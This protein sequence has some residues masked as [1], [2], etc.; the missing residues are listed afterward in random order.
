MKR[1]LI[2]FGFMAAAVGAPAGAQTA[3]PVTAPSVAAP[4]TTPSVATRDGLLGMGIL[5]GD[6]TAGTVKYWIDDI[7]AIAGGIGVSENLLLYADYV[8]HGWDL[9]PQPK[10]GRLAA[11]AAIGGRLEFTDDTDFG[12]RALPGVSYWPHFKRPVEF[13][14]EVGPTFRLTKGLRVR[15]EGGFGL[16]V[17]FTPR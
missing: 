14:L 13:F 2:L 5:L 8:F 15:A 7:Q 6:P 1:T 16:R 17:Y 12:L 4:M 10:R 9:I 11:Y 3:E